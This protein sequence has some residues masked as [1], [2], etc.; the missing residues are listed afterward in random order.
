VE[1]GLTSRDATRTIV[2]GYCRARE[3]K[4]QNGKAYLMWM[5]RRIALVVG[6]SGR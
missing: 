6:L 2:M 3:V 5:A 4:G 1:L